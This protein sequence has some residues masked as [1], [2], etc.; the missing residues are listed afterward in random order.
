MIDQIFDTI[1]RTVNRRPKLVVGIIGV[2]FVIALF[3]MTMIVMETGNDTYLDKDSVAGI[4]NKQ[5]TDTFAADSLILIFET[6]DPT[7]PDVLKYMDR[8]EGNIR[9]Q[10]HIASAASVVD[11]L[12]QMNGGGTS[13]VQGRDRCPDSADPRRQPLGAG[14]IERSLAHAGQAR[15]RAL[16]RHQDICAQ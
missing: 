13:A 3:G 7:S 11:T 12:K 8:L 5:Y 15:R 1:A 4:A 14:A 6:S 16:G 10:Q 2:I 9:Q